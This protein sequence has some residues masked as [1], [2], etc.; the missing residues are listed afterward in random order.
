MN[1]ISRLVRTSDYA[2]AANILSEQSGNC[3]SPSFSFSYFIIPRAVADI[4][5]HI[6][7]KNEPY[8]YDTLTP[9]MSC[10]ET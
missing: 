1:I 3:F 8:R 10:A 6:Y 4:T 5:L 2:P 9:V 7:I